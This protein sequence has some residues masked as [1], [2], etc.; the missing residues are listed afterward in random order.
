MSRRWGQ[1]MTTTFIV[2]FIATDN[3]LFRFT[4]FF[5]SLIRSLTTHPNPNPTTIAVYTTHFTTT[6]QVMASETTSL[7][8]SDRI[9][10]TSSVV[11]V[12]RYG[13]LLRPSLAVALVDFYGAL[14]TTGEST[15]TNTRHDLTW[16]HTT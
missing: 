8:R 1:V 3:H 2:S 6:P 4:H 5:H 13:E 14:N 15:H 11:R 10:S 16:Q 7:R 9:N 12:N